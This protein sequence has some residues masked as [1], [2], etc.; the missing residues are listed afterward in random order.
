MP[1]SFDPEIRRERIAATLFGLVNGPGA[2]WGSEVPLETAGAWRAAADYVLALETA[3]G[4]TAGE[5]RDEAIRSRSSTES[6][7]A[8]RFERLKAYA[9]E[10]GFWHDVASILANG[11]LGPRLADGTYVY[12]PPTYAQQLNLAIWKA[13]RA[14]AILDNLARHSSPSF[15]HALDCRLLAGEICSCGLVELR[16]LL[17]GREFQ[18]PTKLDPEQTEN[19]DEFH[20]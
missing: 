5:D 18:G 19:P 10:H 20:E 17:A 1:D 14:Q 2:E 16:A 4:Q 3:A 12:E 8:E 7:Y 11:T 6:W 13:E 15:R 9:K